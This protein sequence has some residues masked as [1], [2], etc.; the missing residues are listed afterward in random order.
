[1]SRSQDEAAHNYQVTFA[2]CFI[3]PDIYVLQQHALSRAGKRKA[4]TARQLSLRKVV[5]LIL[6]AQHVPYGYDFLVIN[7]RGKVIFDG[8]LKIV[9]NSDRSACLALGCTRAGAAI[10]RVVNCQLPELQRQSAG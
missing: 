10:D 1:M 3:R 7:R 2:E 6:K 9:G 4:I 8:V 5:D